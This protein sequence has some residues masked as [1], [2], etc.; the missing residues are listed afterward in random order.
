GVTG[1]EGFREA[2]QRIR[3][4]HGQGLPG[5]VWSS[6]KSARITDLSSDPNFPRASA[7]AAVGIRSAVAVPVLAGEEVIAIL[8]FFA[9]EPD[10][11]DPRRLRLVSSVGA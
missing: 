1:L 4:A 10:R 6:R 5:R 8:E 7:A 3:F 2:S 11:E 9:R